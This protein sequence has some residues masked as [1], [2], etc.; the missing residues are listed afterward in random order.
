MMESASG[1]PGAKSRPGGW[2][3]VIA[4]VVLFACLDGHGSQAAAQSIAGT[5]PN[6]VLIN[7]DD[8]DWAMFERDFQPGIGFRY[9]PNIARLADEGQRYVNFHVP[10][11]ICGPSRACLLS[12]QYAHRVGIRCNQPLENSARGVPGGYDIWRN[13]GPGGATGPRW[14]ESHLGARLKDSGYRTMLVGKYLHDGFEPRPGEDWEDLLRPGG[15]DESYVSLGADYYRTYQIVNGVPR[16]TDGLPPGQ[17]PSTYRTDVEAV[18]A[19]RLISEHADG[20]AGN[21]FFLYFAPLTP[22]RESVA[23]QSLDESRPDGGMVAHRFRHWWPNLVQPFTPD[24][25]EWDTSDKPSE[26]LAL[27]PL[28]MTGSSWADNELLLA[29]VEYRRRALA[30]RTVD[31]FVGDLFELLEERQ[32]SDDTI[33]LLTSD[34]GYQLGHH[35]S[36]GKGLPHDRLT[37]VPLL[38]WGPGHVLPRPEGLKYLLSQ[39][40]L[41]PTLLDLAGVAAGSAMPGKS[42]VPLLEG[43]YQGYFRDWRPEGVLIEHWQAIS[44]RD[45]RVRSSWAGVRMFDSVYVEWATGETEH[46][47]LATDPW[48]LENTAPF[49]PPGQQ[50]WFQNLLSLHR[51]GLDRPAS[52]FE[53]PLNSEQ[54]FAQSAMLTG[55]AECATDIR[56]VRLVIR[57]VTQGPGEWWNGTAWQP[58]FVTVPARLEAMDRTLVNWDYQFAPPPNESRR[59]Q[60]SCR[61]WGKNGS[62]QP[63]PD[64]AHVVLENSQPYGQVASPQPGQVVRRTA[65]NPVQLKGFACDTRGI[66]RARL[67]IRKLSS[68][69]Y[70]NGQAWTGTVT[71]V[72]TVMLFN[73]GRT[74][75]DWDYAFLPPDSSGSVDVTLRMIS[76]VANAPVKSYTRRIH[77]AR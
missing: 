26:L 33:I 19:L 38:A 53:S 16:R 51:L 70:W 57:D 47:N 15:W 40:D 77:W 13:Q 12:G 45:V 49:L 67:V 72:P 4:A 29:D 48:Q 50:V 60:V 25:N 65:G 7:L 32:I 14:S 1:F 61:A 68:G 34:N 8:A 71:T 46:Y 39:V 35:R 36:F 17:Y 69:Q 64:T 27:P 3:R 62:S 20:Q 31:E 23:Q 6:I 52:F 63:V 37:R 74:W 28:D 58:E 54:V 75:I 66:N 11:P 41:A 10:T 21:P 73:A 43:S 42:L 76:E 9:F 56:E 5:R 30:M 24:F 59:C 2:W 18:D 22:H 55:V 44:S